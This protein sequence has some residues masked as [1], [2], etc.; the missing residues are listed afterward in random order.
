[1]SSIGEEYPDTANSSIPRMRF[2]MQHI[3]KADVLGRHVSFICNIARK[4]VLF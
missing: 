3:F 1:M 2:L 4:A